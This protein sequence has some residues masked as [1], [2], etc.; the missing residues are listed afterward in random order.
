MNMLEALVIVRNCSLRSA[1][2][3]EKRGQSALKVV[4]KKIQSLLR[5]AAWR[6]SDGGIPVHMGSDS[7]L[8]PIPESNTESTETALT[9]R[10]QS[11]EAQLATVRKTL[12]GLQWYPNYKDGEH[13]IACPAVIVEGL[14]ADLAAAEKDKAR[15]D[16]LEENPVHEWGFG[17]FP[18]SITMNGKVFM[19]VR[20]AIDNWSATPGKP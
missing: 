15:L 12:E 11:L 6:N 18:G 2:M 16:W 17:A 1:Q 3:V 9:Q 14:Q 10:V 8:Y 7:F 4:D 19:S 20:A 13:W 5:K